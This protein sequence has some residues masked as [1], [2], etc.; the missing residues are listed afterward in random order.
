MWLMRNVSCQS[1]SACFLLLHS[2]SLWCLQIRMLT[3]VLLPWIRGETGSIEASLKPSQPL[4][5][6]QPSSMNALETKRLPMPLVLRSPIAV[7]LDSK[8]LMAEVCPATLP[9]Y[10]ERRNKKSQILSSLKYAFWTKQYKIKPVST[11]EDYVMH[12]PCKIRSEP[13]QW[14]NENHL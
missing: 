1:V 6:I 3:E 12:V 7:F 11:S 8:S 9:Q 10:W 5:T 4:G 14:E 2:S 13:I